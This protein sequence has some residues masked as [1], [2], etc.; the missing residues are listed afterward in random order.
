MGGNAHGFFHVLP[1]FLPCPLP[2]IARMT[3]MTMTTIMD[4]TT[5]MPVTATVLAGTRLP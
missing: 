4:K 3:T 1:G 5:T 2:T